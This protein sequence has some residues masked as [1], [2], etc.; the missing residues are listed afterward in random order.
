MPTTPPV[1]NAMRAPSARPPGSDAAAAT[2]TL[3]RVASHMPR[4]PIAAENAAPTRKKIERPSLTPPS[5]GSRNS[6]A[7][8]TTANSASVRNCRLR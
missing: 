6:N 2:R 3:A 8:T 4:K 1:R 7:Q 5:P